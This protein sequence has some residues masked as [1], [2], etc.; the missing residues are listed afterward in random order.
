[1]LLLARHGRGGIAFLV[2]SLL[3]GV[4]SF[5]TESGSYSCSI[6]P[7]TA[8]AGVRLDRY[9]QSKNDELCAK[10]ASK[11]LTTR[12]AMSLHN[13]PTLWFVLAAE[14]DLFCFV[15]NSAWHWVSSAAASSLSL[16]IRTSIY[17]LCLLS[18]SSLLNTVIPFPPFAAF[19]P[20]A[21]SLDSASFS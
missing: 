6:M 15:A 8:S 13:S 2:P 9:H 5:W 11:V 20:A 16:A 12:S 1:M 7:A 19:S 14:L 3:R 10:T 18:S 4:D 17:L 21:T